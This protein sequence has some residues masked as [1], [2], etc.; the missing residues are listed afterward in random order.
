MILDNPVQIVLMVLNPLTR[1]TIK[2]TVRQESW[3]QKTLS[4]LGQI[5]QCSKHRRI[6]KS[7]PYC[8]SAAL[9]GSPPAL[10]LDYTQAQTPLELHTGQ[11]NTQVK[12]MYSNRRAHNDPDAVPESVS[13]GQYS[14][15]LTVRLAF[16]EVD[17]SACGIVRI[18]QCFHDT[19]EPIMQYK[20]S[21]YT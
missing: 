7:F 21:K 20:E 4:A 3:S 18:L 8:P 13:R 9:L 5:I 14:R 17:L 6:Y 11:E 15:G 16:P 2:V 12:S 10:I 19:L 1:S